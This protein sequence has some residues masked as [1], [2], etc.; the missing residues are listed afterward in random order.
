MNLLIV[1]ATQFEIEPFIR[2]KKKADILI[3]GVGIPATVYHLTQKLMTKKYDLVIQAGI[4]GSFSKRLNLGGVVAIKGD[5]FADLGI[6]EKGNL[7][8]LFETSFIK[9]NDFPFTNGWLVNQH[10]ILQKMSLPVVNAISINKISDSDFQN[11]MMFEKFAADVESMEGAGFHY[12]CLQQKTNFLQLRSISNYI[13]ERDKSKWKMTEAIEN[14][15][16]ELI[17][18]VDNL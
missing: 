13:G 3:T 18:I 7:Q 11:K 10:L 15:N 14:L 17:K 5:T 4:A 8:T 6:E 16:K 9:K 2:H 1:A 12:V